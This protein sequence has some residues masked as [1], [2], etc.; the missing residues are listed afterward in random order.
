M[1]FTH[2]TVSLLR[3]QG[4]TQQQAY[5]RI[6]SLLQERYKRWYVLLSEVPIYDERTDV[7]IR[8]YMDACEKIVVGNVNW[9]YV[10]GINVQC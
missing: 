9:R 4:L 7:E 3:S 10:I 1:G 2:S 8:K 6:D 5:D